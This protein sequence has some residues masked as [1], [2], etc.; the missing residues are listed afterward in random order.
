MKTERRILR[1][2]GQKT[3][4]ENDKRRNRDEQTK[5]ADSIQYKTE[6]LTAVNEEIKTLETNFSEKSQALNETAEN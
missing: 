2:D 4:L 3:T 6:R 5:L 1:A